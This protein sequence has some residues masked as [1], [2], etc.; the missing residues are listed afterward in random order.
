MTGN[1]ESEQSDLT[2]KIKITDGDYL[3]R[4]LRKR[5]LDENLVDIGTNSK[6]GKADMITDSTNSNTSNWKKS[7]GRGEDGHAMFRNMLGKID[8]VVMPE[9]QHFNK[10]S[11]SYA[12]ILKGHRSS[13]SDSLLIGGYNYDPTSNPGVKKVKIFEKM[14]GSLLNRYLSRKNPPI[15]LMESQTG[16]EFRKKVLLNPGINKCASPYKT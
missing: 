8:Y 10:T 3:E 1:R 11:R 16:A 7:R 6:G 15:A 12:G 14:Q 9:I 5:E 2:I 13:K 4:G